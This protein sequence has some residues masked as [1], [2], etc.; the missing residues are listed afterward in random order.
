MIEARD[1]RAALHED[2]SRCRF[3]S[4]HPSDSDD[5][6]RLQIRDAER[7]SIF[8]RHLV[9]EII[10]P[11]IERLDASTGQ[12]RSRTARRGPVDCRH[13]AHRNCS[14]DPN[15]SGSH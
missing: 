7:L 2:V 13:G 12:V 3:S 5:F 11:R 10:D 1:V 14:D 6:V 8:D 4:R 15:D 9:R